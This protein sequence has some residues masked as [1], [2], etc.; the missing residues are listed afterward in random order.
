MMA[1]ATVST[2]SATEQAQVTDKR[3]MRACSSYKF[4]DALILT[5]HVDVVLTAQ[6]F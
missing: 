1:S 5:R 2:K 6:H 4:Q 3:L